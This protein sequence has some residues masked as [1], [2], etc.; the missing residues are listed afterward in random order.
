MGARHTKHVETEFSDP[1]SVQ[2]ARSAENCVVRHRDGDEHAIRKTVQVELIKNI[3]NCLFPVDS[4]PKGRIVLALWGYS[5]KWRCASGKRI[6]VEFRIGG[7]RSEV[8]IE[9]DVSIVGARVQLR[10]CKLRVGAGG[11]WSDEVLI[12]GGDQHTIVRASTGERLNSERCFIN[13]EPRVWLGRRSLVLKNTTIGEGAIVGAG[14]IVTK[15]VPPR[16]AVGGN[17]AKVIKEDVTWQ[18]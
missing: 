4:A 10:G 14:A 6:N 17:P 1:F 15:D 9:R 3:G 8:S 18:A 13:F 2:E 7:R 5:H 16:C 11:L 12:Q